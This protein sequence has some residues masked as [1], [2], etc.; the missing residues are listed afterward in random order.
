MKFS[1]LATGNE[2]IEKKVE[3]LN[4]KYILEKL[5][6]I[7]MSVENIL[8]IKD[9][10][11]NFDKSLKFLL[12]DSDIIFI[13]GG[14]GPT[15]D[16]ITIESISKYFGFDMV[17]NINVKNK[18]LEYHKNK[19]DIDFKALKKQSKVIKNAKIINNDY[20]TAPGQVI[21]VENK[22]IILLPGPPH[23]FINVF[24]KIYNNLDIF[25]KKKKNNKKYLYFYNVTEMDLTSKLE[26]IDYK[27]NYGI[28][29][30]KNLGL[31]LD[32]DINEKILNIF[33]EYYGKRFLGEQNLLDVFFNFV[34]QNNL[35]LSIAESCTGG[36]VADLITSKSGASDFFEA[37]FVTYSNE[38]KSKILKVKKETLETYG[39]VSNECVL[40][41]VKGLNELTKTNISISISGIAGPAG[42]TKEK[43]VGTVYFGFIIDGREYSFKKYFTGNREDIRQKSTYYSLWK[44]LDLYQTTGRLSNE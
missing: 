30:I 3:D 41:M 18:I 27:S 33:Q 29:I 5:L 6:E 37:S 11:D 1:I 12:T 31:R 44:V 35:S 23:E 24:E 2:I 34:K 40:E 26:N 14:L 7:D 36:K 9:N 42:G 43:P 4:S 15:V 13:I 21:K 19:G 39:A 25:D 8:T 38:I 28:Y 20:G 17:E 32:L 16:D 22:Y 10:K